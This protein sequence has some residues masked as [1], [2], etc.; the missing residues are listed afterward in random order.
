MRIRTGIL[1]WLVVLPAALNA[2]QPAPPAA[3]PQKPAAQQAPAYQPIVIY[4]IDLNPTG[5]AFSIDEPKLVDDRWV[6]HSLPDRT[7]ERVPKERI[8]AITRRSRDF[9]KE[10]VWRVEFVPN[11][12]M[13]LSEEPVK[14]GANYLLKPWKGGTLVSIAQAEVKTI[15]RV[16]GMDAFRAEEEELGVKLLEGEAHF[17]HDIPDAPPAG[18]GPGAPAAAAPGGKPAQGNWTYQGQPGA[19]DAYAPASGTQ[20][21]PGDTPKAPEPTRPPN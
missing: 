14:K 2:Q 6:F 1:A 9:D 21:R 11:G 19:S 15:T 10:V 20:A 5:S 17:R 16:T 18:P 7:L 13:L 8:K 3:A 4:R 12:Q